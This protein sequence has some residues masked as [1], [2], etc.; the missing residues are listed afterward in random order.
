MVVVDQIVDKIS[1]VA[2]T[3]IF[4]HVGYLFQYNEN[5]HSLEV[6]TQELEDLLRRINEKVV[7][8]QNNGEVIQP[9]VDKWQKD[10]KQIQDESTTFLVN[11]VRSN[12][13]CVCCW[14]PNLVWRYWL[15][16]ESKLMASRV[17]SLKEKGTMY[18]TEWPLSSPAPP[19]DR[20]ITSHEAFDSRK[21]IF[22]SIMGALKDPTIKMIGVHGTGGVGK[23][24]MVKEVGNVAKRDGVFDD[25]AIAVVSRNLD[26]KNVQ[27]ELAAQLGL[28]LDDHGRAD[29]LW[30]RLQN[31][32]KN[33]VILDD[34]WDPLKLEE[35]GI[36]NTTDYGNKEG[37]C[38]V[39][40][41]SRKNLFHMITPEA[42]TRVFLI[43]ILNEKE[44]WTLF[45]KTAEISVNSEE[46][47]SCVEKGV[48]D[49]CAGL[50]VAILAVAKAL[51][52][53]ESY[54]WQDALTQLKSSN[55]N[56]I[57]DIDPNLFSSL[58]FSYDH[59]EPRDARSCF[60]LCSLF[61]EDA[62]ISIDDLVRY[63]F[64]MRL[65]DPTLSIT[66]ENIRNRVLTLVKGLKASCL[67]Q[68]GKD[69][70]T[71]KMHDV[72]RDI[73]I[74]IAKDEKGY[75]VKHDLKK[76][77][78]K[79]TYKSYSAI[80]LMSEYFNEIPVELGCKELHTL[81]LRSKDSSLPDSFF[82]GMETN[83]EVLDLS[84][85]AI[86]SLPLSLSKL[87]KLR[88]LCLP[89]G[90]A[91]EIRQL[92]CL[93][94]LDLGN[95][96][97]VRLSV[98]PPNVLSN[99][100]RM[101]EL[102]IPDNFDQWQDEATSKERWNASLVEL[103]SLTC[104]TTLK[105]H[106]P[107]GKSSPN[108]LCFENLLRF[109]ISIGAHFPR[110]TYFGNNELEQSFT[111]I[112]KLSSVPLEDKFKGLL[113]KSEVLYLHKVKGL[114]EML[115]ASGFFNLKYL[116]VVTCDGAEYLLGRPDKFLQTPQ[117]SMSRSF[118]NLSTLIVE[119]CTFKYLFNLSVVRCLEQLQVLVVD[120]C[121]NM[122]V[123][124]E[125][126]R[127]GDDEEITFPRLTEMILTELP[128]LRSFC[129]SK[130]PNSIIGVSNSNPEQPLFC[131]KV[132]VPAL[133]ELT[134]FHLDNISE[135]WDKQY[136]PIMNEG[137][138]SFSL[139]RSLSVRQCPR[140][141]N[142][143]PFEMVQRLR[144]FKTL[145]VWQC[146]SVV[147]EIEDL[148]VAF[149]QLERLYL[150]D[151]QNLRETGLNKKE[152]HGINGVYPN[153]KEIDIDSCPNLESIFSSSTAKNL[154]HLRRLII[155]NDRSHSDSKLKAIVETTKE[156]GGARDEPFVFPELDHM[157]LRKMT[158]LR[159]FCNS[160]GPEESLFNQKVVFP[161]L[162]YLDISRLGNMKGIWDRTPPANSFQ[163]LT[164][165][166]LRA[167]DSLLY[168]APSELLGSLQNLQT[169]EIE[170]CR[171][172]E[173]VFKN[174]GS[175]SG[176]GIVSKHEP[177]TDE[178]DTKVVL[179]R[180]RLVF[181]RDLP[182][183]KSFCSGSKLPSSVRREIRNCPLLGTPF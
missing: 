37:C 150:D 87:V 113:L 161:C 67:L 49:E 19:P 175:Y 144:N 9:D 90:L 58:K 88:M 22:N 86:E 135:I 183:L 81:V 36:P 79:G 166:E 115:R 156:R 182:R 99:L 130:R 123:I 17:I 132:V 63:N 31:G 68:D 164:F 116:Q 28:H 56:Q 45:M 55:F 118:C 121:S 140:L 23:T 57:V 158:D 106:I 70:S 66:L 148:T 62:E 172:L 40:V 110:I 47:L 107:Q 41:T 82:N 128:N 91:S 100:T 15:G 111:S 11:K 136:K 143:V 157:E 112:L 139:L 129:S 162:E 6:E 72:I 54:A 142:V 69:A 61:P 154:A 65:L 95:N 84:G 52:G 117:Q 126:E 124:V 33:L 20:P 181:L 21:N 152:D 97:D 138:G 127:Q 48:C 93:K 174:R 92:T 29:K 155:R 39:L 89:K 163:K 165:L 105:V 25:V 14:C 108:N 10:A 60:L 101:E 176:E 159:S 137:T 125:I 169:L 78:D 120:D 102:C 141:V 13:W 114:V 160:Y 170:S 30:T 53:K 133:E 171:L 4:C 77:P 34:V 85:T 149:P 145:K 167:C 18:Y 75:L 1:E 109:A 51:K 35:I 71:V 94:L 3:I 173:D 7:R 151:L 146:D 50:P 59:L 2:T 44:A 74:S 16:K 177:T 178:V 180:L 12:T 27:G 83:L 103:N 80:S 42:S 147:H 168:V 24:T 153:I 73:A 179:P 96:E 8:S 122:E 64:G 131:E 104:L 5:I 26:K 98:I 46:E 38:K 43:P 134:I 76:W 119:K 32:K